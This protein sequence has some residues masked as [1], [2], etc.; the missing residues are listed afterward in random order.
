M[1]AH[2]RANS[3]GHPTLRSRRRGLIE[4]PIVSL[5]RRLALNATAFC[6]VSA[7]TA[8]KAGYYAAVAC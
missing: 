3:E 5:F 4:P 6:A 2:L 1:T 7:M 8:Q